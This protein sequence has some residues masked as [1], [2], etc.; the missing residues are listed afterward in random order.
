MSISKLGISALFSAIGSA[1]STLASF[2]CTSLS[3]SK[4][5]VRQFEATST[6]RM[7]VPEGQK[8]EVRTRK[9]ST[10]FNVISPFRDTINRFAVFSRHIFFYA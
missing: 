3:V 6:I 8:L 9:L 2:I 7:S 4:C 1:C 5:R 10:K